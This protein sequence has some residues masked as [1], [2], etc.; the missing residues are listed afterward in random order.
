MK[1][2]P[3]TRAAWP[4]FETLMGPKGGYGGCWCMLWRKTKAEHD[5]DSGE[6]NRRDIARLAESEL[7]PGLIA[8]DGDRPAGWISVAPRDAFVELESSRVLKPVDAQAVWSVSCFLIA[9]DYRR[10]GLAV[11]LLEAACDFVRRQG[12]T[13]LEG[14]P[15]APNKTPYP[16][17]YAWTGF[18][19]AF[20]K[21][22]FEEVAR[23]SPTRPILRRVLS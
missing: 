9:K 22:G 11:R 16:A 20:E 7:P 19:S 23:R 15:I 17:A 1:I 14:Y 2:E 12:G 4:A 3:L 13:I 10:Q 6:V 18:A 8:L 5:R 21:A